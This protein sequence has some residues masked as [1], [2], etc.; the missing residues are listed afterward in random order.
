MMFLCNLFRDKPSLHSHNFLGLK[1]RADG[2]PRSRGSRKVKCGLDVAT[3]QLYSCKSNGKSNSF[4][5]QQFDHL[6]I[7]E[8]FSRSVK[9]FQIWSSTSSSWLYPLAIKPGSGQIP[10][11][12]FIRTSPMVHGFQHAM[13]TGRHMGLSINGLTSY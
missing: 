7:A 9:L 5:G 10:M 11:E 6:Q 3:L 8:E 12:G 4:L 2:G 13:M 1:K